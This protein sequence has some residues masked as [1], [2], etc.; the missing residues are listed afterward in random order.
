MNDNQGKSLIDSF[1]DAAEAVVGKVETAIG[2]KDKLWSVDD[3]ID[4]RGT[5]YRITSG[6]QWLETDDARLA[7]KVCDVL[8][9]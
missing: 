8:N 7:Q 4:D 2:D 3:V 9:G 5:V 1:F 6:K